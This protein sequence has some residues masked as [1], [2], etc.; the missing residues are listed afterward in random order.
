MLSAAVHP[1]PGDTV[2]WQTLSLCGGSDR[3]CPD[4]GRRAS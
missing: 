3:L 2:R 4:H 1:T